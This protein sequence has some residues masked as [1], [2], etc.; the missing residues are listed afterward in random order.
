M[1]EAPDRAAWQKPDAV[2][3]ALR[4][5]PGQVVADIGASTGY[6]SRRLAQAVGPSG[7]VW[8]LDV[9]PA[10]VDYVNARARRDGQANL[11]ARRVAPDDPGLGPN[12]VDLVLIVDTLHHIDARPIYYSRLLRALRPKGRIVVIDFLPHS[13]IGPRASERLPKA[14]VENELRAAGLRIAKSPMSLPY[15]YIIVAT[16]P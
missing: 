14:Q 16:R 10:L 5:R 1:F 11:V 7:K 3:A 12:S 15:Q 8:A 13:P 4:L 6:F 2:V 9:A